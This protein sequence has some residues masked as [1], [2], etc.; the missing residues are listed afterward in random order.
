MKADE[1]NMHKY[2]SWWSNINIS[3]CFDD[4][5]M[6]YYF[7]NFAT[8]AETERWVWWDKRG[9]TQL[10]VSDRDNISQLLRSSVKREHLSQTQDIAF[11]L[12]WLSQPFKTSN[13]CLIQADTDRIFCPGLS[14][15]EILLTCNC[16]QKNSCEWAM[17]ILFKFAKRSLW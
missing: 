14:I 6:C 13:N 11:Q 17:S 9:R 3:E 15:K 12:M 4:A 7:D 1:K 10:F 8:D 16:Q 2:E 5:R